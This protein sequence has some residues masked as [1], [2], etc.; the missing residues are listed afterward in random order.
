MSSSGDAGSTFAKITQGIG[1]DVAAVHAGAVDKDARFPAEAFAALR[2]EKLLSAYVPKEL[3]GL[4]CT[5]KDLHV[6]CYTLG[7]HCANT[8]MVFA[9]HQIQVAC[10]VRHGLKS[11]LLT[12]YVTEKVVGEQHLI[13]SATTEAGIGG[14]VRSSSCAVE[15]SGDTFN[16]KKNAPVISYADSADSLLV[17]ARR[18]PESPASDQVISLVEKGDYTLERTSNWDTLG[19]RG[20]CSNGY[21]LTASGPAGKILPQPYA[22]ISAQTMLPVAHLV[23]PSLWLGLA[24]SAVNQARA[25]IRSEARKRPGAVPPASMRLAETMAVLQGMKA[26]VEAAVADYESRLNDPEALS[27]IAFALRMN[28]LKVEVSEQVVDVVGRAMRI[29]GIQGYKHDSK[30]T[31]G[32]HLRD[33]WGAQLMVNNDRILGHNAQLLLVHKDE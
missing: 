13:A 19:F 33:A 11:P 29:C 10:L 26:N 8:A 2:K 22:E 24:T 7:L 31:L 6:M 15:L 3:G 20:T 32:R 1:A 25:F 14:D 30:F 28:N 21:M 16:L 5:M 4:G 27:A 18:A 12:K 23:W 17:T 9:M